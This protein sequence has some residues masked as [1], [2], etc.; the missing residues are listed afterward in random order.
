MRQPGSRKAR[1]YASDKERADDALLSMDPPRDYDTWKDVSISY[2]AAGGDEGTYLTWCKRDPEKY[3]KETARKLFEHVEQDGRITAGT[4]FWHARQHGWTGGRVS[5][6]TAHPTSSKAPDLPRISDLTPIQQAVAQLKALF[7]PGEHVNLSVRARWDERRRKWQPA[8][9]G[10]CYERDEL[11]GLL[12]SEGFGGVLEGYQPEAGIWVCQNPTDGTGRGKGKAAAYRHALIE[13]DE[14]PV[15]EQ[16]RIMRELD[17]PVASVTLSGDKSAHALVHVD[18][19]GPEH[20]AERV[21]TLHE[22]CDAAGLHV[23]AAN[24]DVSRLTRL[25][26]AQ[27]GN[28]RQSLVCTN[29]GAKDFHGWAESHRIKPEAADEQTAAERFERLFAP[30]PATRQELPPVLIENT[31]RKQAVMLIGAAPKVGKTFLAAQLTVGFATGTAVLG[32]GLA[33]CERILV[34]N[35]EM[36][37]AEYDNRIIDA[38]LSDET[39]A[40][41]AK[42][43]RVAH[44]D[45]SP[46]LTVKE[47]AEIVCESGYRPDVVIIDPIYPLFVGDENSNA[48]AKTTLAYLKIIASRTGAGVI[49]M[50]H[51]SKGPQDLKEARDR[52]SGAG[53]LGRNYAAMWSLTELAPSDEEMADLPDGSVVVRVSID[54]RS[55]KKSK[56]NKNL[57]FNAVRMDGMFFRDDDGRFDKTPTREAARRAEASKKA[58]QREK[59]MEKAR[60]KIKGLLD[61]NGGEPVPFSTVQNL[62]ALSANTIKDYLMDMDEYMLVKMQVDG[63]GQRRNH[64]AWAT[65]QPPLGAELVGDG[66]DAD[67]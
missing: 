23:D 51:F 63:K 28:A 65:W 61:K 48:D 4:L 29:A 47:I 30:L 59:R 16:L 8:D 2:K 58:A 13:S 52:V 56:G 3:D 46:E 64:I 1:T 25:A 7:E 42:H 62:T 54:L 17:L 6:R 53:T 41:V 20:Y 67:A 21:G 14:I 11:I 49:Y 33:K 34:V 60:K 31:F 12:Q 22:I 37:Q 39:A 38:A 24:K 32:F 26:G 66:G 44:T 18:A 5:E 19:E 27:R 57:D 55:F 35:S 15:A 43:V 36:N 10:A 9:G 45:D 50:H 40:E